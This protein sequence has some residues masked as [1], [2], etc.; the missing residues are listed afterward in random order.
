MQTEYTADGAPSVLPQEFVLLLQSMD[1]ESAGEVQQLISKAKKQ[2]VLAHHQLAISQIHSSSKYKDGKWKTHVI[3]DGK[4]TPVWSKLTG[5]AGEEEIYEY[6][7]SHYKAQETVT[8]FE[9]VFELLM[10]H[11]QALGR[12]D[13]TISEDRRR[14]AYIPEKLRKTPVDT[15][16]ED[17]LRRWLVTDFLPRKPKKEGLKKMIQLLKAVFTYGRSK[18][19]LRENPAEFIDFRDYAN[20]C[21]T[22][23]KTNEKRS[24][25]DEELE[26]LKAYAIERRTNPHAA[27]ILIS[28]ETG[29]RAGELAALKKAD[30]SDG[31]IHVHDQQVRRRTKDD[32][33]CFQFAG[34]TKNERQNPKNGRWIPVT[35]ACAEALQI[36]KELPGE[37]TYVLHNK[38]GNPI[39]KDSYEQY[40]RRACHSLGIETTHNHAFRVAFNA[41]LIADDI[42]GND[43]SLILGHSA[44]TNERHYSFS[45]QRRL[46]R[47]KQKMTG[48]Q[49]Q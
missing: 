43:R 3:K 41:R 8:T 19:H 29:M 23:T 44:Q 10:Q 49:E 17:G 27:A 31:Y 34:Y 25:S 13:Q 7:Y 21:D 2:Y 36:A 28:M 18:K 42:D 39:I 40:L 14:F 6:L 32:H 11:K 16:T 22:Q 9:D 1:T 5:E 35:H 4:R 20:Q 33:Q 24:F 15:V 30:V 26:K 37:S 48:E 45:D 47:I 12:T 38:S 46:D